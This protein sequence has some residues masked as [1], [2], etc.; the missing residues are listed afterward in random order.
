VRDRP[1]IQM[2]LI[3]L[4]GLAILLPI[5]LLAIPWFPVKGS[6]Q[7]G[8]IHT[9]YDVLLIAS[10]PMF[11]LVETV[12][13]YSVW[14][15]R[16]KPGE[17]LKDG[18]P[19]HGNT[20]LEVVWTALPAVL[21]L[22]LCGYA[23]SVLRSNEAA[24]ADSLTVAVTA[25][26]FAFEFD[27]P[28]EGPGGKTIVS[29]VLY[30]PEGRPVVFQ[31]RSLDVIHSFFVPEFSEKLDA[32][33]GITTTLRATPNRVGSY[34][35]ECTELCGAGHGLMRSSVRVVTPAAFQSW[36]AA[37]KSGAPPVGTPPGFANQPGIPGG[38]GA[39]SGSGGGSFSSSSGSSSSSSSGSSSSS[40]GG[41]TSSSSGG[42]SSSSSGIPQGATAGDR[43]SDN[44]GGPSDGDG[45][46]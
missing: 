21:I 34:P 1:F 11:V 29:P 30:L 4:I 12:V 15:F 7:A 38:A 18:P 33:P 37:Q 27:Y 39:S 44:R 2:G 45:N 3:G 26:Q 32:V 31:L 16:M 20:R 42:A 36:M 28:G 19:I 35:V 25:R 14:K 23:Y 8:H 24:K 13:I 6:V 9:L 17:E 10:V 5:A 46:V 41:S 43:D 40:S 22:G